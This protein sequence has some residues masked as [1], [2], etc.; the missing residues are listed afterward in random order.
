MIA[1]VVRTAREDLTSG[2]SLSASLGK[3][4][5]FPPM[6]ARMLSAGEATGRLDETL[7]NVSK[8]YD[9]EVPKTIKKTFAILEPAIIIFLATVVLG[10]ALSFFL[11]LYK[12]V[13]ALGGSP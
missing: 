10:A 12:M 9:R 2:G 11:A 1:S 13:G 8:H 3:S 5:Q 4:D 7:D 6:V